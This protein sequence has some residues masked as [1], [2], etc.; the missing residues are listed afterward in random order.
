MDK[1]AASVKTNFIM[2][3]WHAYQ[4]GVQ[5]LDLAFPVGIKDV[6]NASQDIH[7]RVADA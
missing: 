1:I 5:N 4:E 3:I 2:K 6:M 7:Q